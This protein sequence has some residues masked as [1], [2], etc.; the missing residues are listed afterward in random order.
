MLLPASA[1]GL[2]AALASMHLPAKS[3]RVERTRRLS[4]PASEIESE[5]ARLA[6][7]KT[8]SAGSMTES[9]GKPPGKKIVGILGR[10]R[11]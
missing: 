10:V 6:L 2:A 1:L 7:Q 5:M 11:E 9:A 8:N 4:Q 3:Y